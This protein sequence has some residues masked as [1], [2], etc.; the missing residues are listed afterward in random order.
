MYASVVAAQPIC[1][2]RDRSNLIVGKRVVIIG[3]GKMSL[4]SVRSPEMQYLE[5]PLSSWDM[6][7]RVYGSSGAL[8]SQ[9]SIG[10]LDRFS[11]KIR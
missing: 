3:W 1:L 4:S 7:L 5:M 9:K 8:D 2:Q 11:Y 6:C 10:K